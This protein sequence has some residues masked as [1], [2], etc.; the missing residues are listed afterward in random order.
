M[1]DLPRPYPLERRQLDN[2]P[3]LRVQRRHRDLRLHL[4]LH[5]RVRLWP[6]HERARACR[7]E[8]SHPAARVA[9]LRRP[10]VPVRDLHGGDRL[11]QRRRSTIRSTPKKWASSTSCGSPTSR[12]CRRCCSSSSL[13]TW[14]CC[15]SM[16]CCW[17][18]F[19]PVLWLLGRLPTLAL[20]ISVA[21][22]AVSLYFDWNFPAYPSGHWYFNPLAWQ[23]LFVA[24]GLVRAGRRR[25]VGARAALPHHARG[26]ASLPAVRLRRDPDLAHSR[27]GRFMPKL[28]VG[29]DLSDRQDQPRHAAVSPLR[30]PG[31]AHRPA[32]RRDWPG[33]KSQLLRPAILCGQHSLE[34]FCLGVFLAFT[35][36]IILVEV[37]D[38]VSMQVAI[39]ALGIALM[40]ATAAL[41][42]WYKV[43]EGRRPGPRPPK[44]DLAGGEA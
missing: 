1:A 8:C 23:L 43:V 14:T 28:A 40:V 35:G 4:R 3:Q 26:C 7:R 29:L 37:S 18:A 9:G 20:A 24:R 5:G 30:G 19:P 34:I 38:R 41:L 17:S 32:G 42:T 21:I 13:P 27:I 36:H 31:R 10:H 39:S 44:M 15:R 12:C 6:G 11:R 33:L 22:Y 25:L 2:D 16:S